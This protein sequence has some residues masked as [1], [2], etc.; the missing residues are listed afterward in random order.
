[1]NRTTPYARYLAA[2]RGGLRAEVRLGSPRHPDCGGHGIC[3]ILLPAATAAL[4]P[5]PARLPAYLRVDAP[6]GRLLLHLDRTALAPQLYRRHFP[7]GRLWLPG[8][9]P[10]PAEV[11]H[12]LG[13]PGPRCLPPGRYPTLEDEHF[14]TLSLPLARSATRHLRAAA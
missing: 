1:M 14:I 4:P 7:D 5:C 12:A 3:S 13:Q 11:L 2:C 6:T 10:L 8:P 9:V